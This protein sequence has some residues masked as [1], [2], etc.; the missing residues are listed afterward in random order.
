MTTTEFTVTAPTRDQLCTWTFWLARDIGGGIEIMADGAVFG[1]HGPAVLN[2][3]DPDTKQA[4]AT[5]PATVTTLRHIAETM[6]TDVVALIWESG[7]PA[8]EN[9]G[10]R[11][12]SL[13]RICFAPMTEHVVDHGV[14]HTEGHCPDCGTREVWTLTPNRSR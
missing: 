2:W 8:T 10:V 1:D 14:I 9:D 12:D 3:R 13:C 5:G 7:G 6:C 4:S 11:T